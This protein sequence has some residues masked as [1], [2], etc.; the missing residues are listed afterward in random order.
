MK[1]VCT[2]H[3]SLLMQCRFPEVN[4]YGKLIAGSR[5]VVDGLGFVGV[6]EF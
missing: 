5:Q 6:F 4:E 3:D 1:C 2:P